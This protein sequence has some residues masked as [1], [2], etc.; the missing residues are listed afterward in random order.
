MRYF[1]VNPKDGGLIAIVAVQPQTWE[2]MLLRDLNHAE[3]DTS[4]YRL[5]VVNTD[6]VA[7]ETAGRDRAVLR[8]PDPERGNM[9]L[10]LNKQ[11]SPN[12]PIMLV[13]QDTGESEIIPPHLVT[14]LAAAPEEELQRHYRSDHEDA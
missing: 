1:L 4:I 13:N 14:I 2:L 10:A 7:P 6:P 8:V 3:E 5:A 9:L 11:E 12:K